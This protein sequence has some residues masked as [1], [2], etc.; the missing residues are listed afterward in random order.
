[1]NQKKKPCNTGWYGVKG[2]CNVAALA[3]PFNIGWYYQ[4]V[5]KGGL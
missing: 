3:G 5:L 4:P 2:S 1:M